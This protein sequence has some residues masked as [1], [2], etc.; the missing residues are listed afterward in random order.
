MGRGKGRRRTIT[1]PNVIL[2]TSYFYT[3]DTN[4]KTII[5]NNPLPDVTHEEFVSLL[6]PLLVPENYAYLNSGTSSN[7]SSPPP[8]PNSGS[9]NPRPSMS[10]PPGRPPQTSLQVPNNPAPLDWIHFEGR[11]VKTT[12][13]NLV[14]LDGLAR[15]KKW[16][17]HCVFSVDVGRK[18]RQGVEAV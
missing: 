6:G 11:S 16:R 17:S 14:G 3:D 4:T 8:L 13:N 1:W 12:L 18:T 9:S 5:N 7:P 10:S 15:E 2:I